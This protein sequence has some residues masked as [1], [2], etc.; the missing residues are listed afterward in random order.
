MSRVP[1][2]ALSAVSLAHLAASPAHLDFAY[3]T[4]NERIDV[5]IS[6]SGRDSLLQSLIL[7]E[8]LLG[9]GL[10]VSY[11]G[12]EGTSA[13]MVGTSEGLQSAT[14]FVQ[15]LSPTS[16]ARS[17]NIRS[18]VQLACAHG[19]PIV[20]LVDHELDVDA[21]LGRA[22]GE[23][24]SGA[25]AHH[26]GTPGLTEGELA[27]LRGAQ[28]VTVGAGAAASVVAACDAAAPPSPQALTERAARSSARATH[29]L[30]GRLAG[31]RSR[32]ELYEHADL[33]LAAPPSGALH[34]AY[35]RCALMQRCPQ[36]R[37]RE[38]VPAL[39]LDAARSASAASCVTAVIVGPTTFSPECATVGAAF[40]A[41]NGLQAQPSGAPRV[42]VLAERDYASDAHALGEGTALAGWAQRLPIV[43][44][45]WQRSSE[46]SALLGSLLEQLGALPVDE[47]LPDFPS[48]GV[49]LRGIQRIFSELFGPA[50]CETLLGR[51]VYPSLLA[52]LRKEE[53]WR[54]LVDER[55][56]LVDI[57]GLFT[58]EELGVS[59][60][61]GTCHSRL[62]FSHTLAALA[63]RAEYSCGYIFLDALSLPSF[64]HTPG[65]RALARTQQVHPWASHVSRHARVSMN[66]AW[67][68]RE[69]CVLPT[70]QRAW[71]IAEIAVASA[72]GATIDFHSV[73][74]PEC[75]EG[76]T[77]EL[78]AVDYEAV[79]RDTL[80]NWTFSS[81][82][83]AD[84]ADRDFLFPI[85]AEC[86]GCNCADARSLDAAVKDRVTGEVHA[87]LCEELEVAIGCTS[88]ARMVDFATSRLPLTLARLL[89]EPAVVCGRN[90]A[91]I[92][93]AAH[94]ASAERLCRQV[95]QARGAELSAPGAAQLWGPRL[96]Q[97]CAWLAVASRKSWQDTLDALNSAYDKKFA[98]LE[99]VLA[100]VQFSTNCV[101]VWPGSDEEGL[102][103]DA[104]VG[105]AGAGKA[106]A[107]PFAATDCP[108]FA[109]AAMK[110]EYMQLLAEDL[111]AGRVVLFLGAGLF[112]P[113]G[114]PDWAELMQDMLQLCPSLE[115]PVKD[116]LAASLREGG[117][118]NY[119][120]VAQV[121]EDKLGLVVYE[122]TLRSKLSYNPSLHERRMKQTFALLRLLPF[123]AILTTNQ[124]RAFSAPAGDAPVDFS[125]VPGDAGI[126]PAQLADFLA[127][128]PLHLAIPAA[129]VLADEP[130]RDAMLLRCAR[131]ASQS[132]HTPQPALQ[133]RYD[134]P[135]LHI[136]GAARAVSTRKSYREL[137]YTT[138][139]LPLL[140]ALST[141]SRFLFLGYSLSDAYLQE[142]LQETLALVLPRAAAGAA[143]TRGSDPP[144]L[145]YVLKFLPPGTQQA[146][147]LEGE[148][149]YR[150]R[151]L[152]LCTIPTLAPVRELEALVGASSRQLHLARAFCGG[153]RV[154]AL[155]PPARAAARVLPRGG[156]EDVALA[157][158][159]L[160]FAAEA[161]AAQGAVARFR[162]HERA[163]RAARTDFEGMLAAFGALGAGAPL[164]PRARP[165]Q[166]LPLP[167]GGELL[168]CF[169]PAQAARALAPGAHALL[170]DWRFEGGGVGGGE[171]EGAEAALLR[172]AAAEAGA[173]RLAFLPLGPEGDAKAA[174]ATAP[175]A[176][177][178]QHLRRARS[179]GYV[180]LCA[181]SKGL[182]TALSD[183]LGGSTA[184]AH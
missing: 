78:L 87:W 129:A 77:A 105:A 167:S 158:A 141:S 125:L 150:L 53:R 16:L 30:P 42:R 25:A 153:V 38:V 14:L 122:E 28:R 164:P 142:L 86:L 165:P 131:D 126:A 120:M 23:L 92:D 85:V 54:G 22:R 116:S 11:W 60:I 137:L 65:H 91:A 89:L 62:P 136:H 145:G 135:C 169:S 111:R 144:R 147:A 32:S 10:L 146:A 72:S 82:F 97:A 51:D 100:Y 75:T 6:Y 48:T 55:R 132:P 168:L 113:A 37:V 39:G 93:K 80:Q 67:G 123:R 182:L 102:Q 57:P 34:A 24:A 8:E 19:K 183:L 2:T 73:F 47:V 98:A 52:R 140:R 159:E 63:A 118:A 12:Q 70:L 155:E 20:L 64:K 4:P 170:V 33:L 49:S 5:F 29:R 69:P 179:L 43:P 134:A 95:V 26:L 114:L 184:P 177:R 1:R 148:M 160:A 109:V 173:A 84:P 58:A 110:A 9:S 27:Y 138:P 154:V 181:D 61:L 21:A 156:M 107:A 161:G 13:D 130:G 83:F 162:A 166:R 76:S 171:G 15:L 74:F 124:T 121:L 44:F 117:S 71:K 94:R 151:H 128:Q 178:A 176:Q 46:R 3:A 81:S 66:F 99:Y 119:E 143:A 172:S 127:L 96:L 56:P 112:K 104:E 88:P 115:A 41:A 101:L 103:R 18:E 40:A 157:L 45:F 175:A 108:S 174:A 163:F 133:A 68:L 36:L 31:Q 35:L 139:V 79:W 106:A 59:T 7:A 180:D 149:D 152:G 17:A 90:G 50:V